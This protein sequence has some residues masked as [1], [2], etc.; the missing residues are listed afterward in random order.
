[1]KNLEPTLT[2]SANLDESF[3]NATGGSTPSSTNTNSGKIDYNAL[4]A[5]G[6]G[7]AT[8][9][10]TSATQ[11]R[12]EEEVACGRPQPTWNAATLDAH[13]KCVENFRAGKQGN[14][15]YQGD[16]NYTPPVEDSSSTNWFLIGGIA[17]AAI[18]LGIGAYFMF[19]KKP[20]VVVPT[21]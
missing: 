4:I 1:M 18:G 11:P 9:L 10:A 15:T 8:V 7:L 16:N 21:P 2:S 19:R 13:N 5:G 17:L 14:G 12:G 6:L 20:P 3:D